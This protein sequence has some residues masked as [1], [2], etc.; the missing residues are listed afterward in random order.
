M[1]SILLNNNFIYIKLLLTN[2]AITI[3]SSI[4]K[5]FYYGYGALF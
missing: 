4:A 3:N 5:I 1:F 2:G